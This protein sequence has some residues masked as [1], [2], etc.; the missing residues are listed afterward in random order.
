M[1]TTEK[2]IEIK[3]K[4]P[5]TGINAVYFSSETGNTDKFVTK[6]GYPKHKIPVDMNQEFL[7]DFDY[8]L[9]CPTYSGGLD[10][11]KGSVPKQVIKFLNNQQNREHCIAI[12]ASGNTNFGDTYGLAGYVLQ[13]KLQ[14]PLLHIYELIGTKHDEEIVKEKIEKLWNQ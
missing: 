2:N 13:A 8:V 5:T 12:V 4:K 6:L 14:V 7:V 3:I 9:F 11:V 10:D 1:N